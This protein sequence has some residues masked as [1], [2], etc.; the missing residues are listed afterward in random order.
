VSPAG[1]GAW[2]P[3]I[4]EPAFPIVVAGHV[5]HGKST[6]IGRLLHDTDSLPDGKAEEVR[7]ISA[8]RGLETEWSFVLDALQLERDQ[9]ITL[10]AS[11]IWFKT[12]RRR[13]VII[14][15]PGHREFLRNML[16]GASAAQAAVL[17]VD[18]VEGISEQT[19]RHAYLLRLLGIE[20]VIVV[21]NKMDRV[22]HAQKHFATVAGAIGTYLTSIGLAG[23]TIIPASARFGDGIAKRSERLAWHRGPTLVEALDVL[24][25][26]AAPD[27]LP[28]R[29]PVQDVY[30]DGD[31]RILVGRIEAGRLRPGERVRI[32]PGGREVQVAGFADGRAEGNARAS[33]ALRLVEAAFVERGSLLVGADSPPRPGEHI[34][35]RVALFAS[36]P[37]RQG[38]ALRL[39]IGPSDYPVALASIDRLVDVERL[40]G[41]RAAEI[42]PDGIAEVTLVAPFPLPLDTAAESLRTGRGVLLDQGRIIGAAIIDR[43]ESSAARNN[44]GGGSRVGPARAFSHRGAVLWLTGLSG[45]GKST[46]A[47]L[48]AQRLAEAGRNATVLDGDLMRQGLSRD[49]GFSPAD[50]AENVRR[51]AEVARLFA[52]AGFVAIVAMISPRREDRTLARRIVGDGFAEVYVRAPLELCIARDPKGLYAK[53]IAGSIREFTGIS[54]PYEEPDAPN[55]MLDTQAMAESDGVTA[56]RDLAEAMLCAG[57]GACATERD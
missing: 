16:S 30:R 49:L 32:L 36:A 9:G 34:T 20:Q 43:V 11:R 26:R 37:V 54:A 29:L 33:V 24:V 46:L 47:R 44:V 52:D 8:L 39:R 56:L 6:L 55:L 2:L 22:G 18:A 40:D 38:T 10:D 45:S 12:A 13:Y 21:I 15:A 1:D 42:P 25:R 57:S 53:A 3:P 51:V 5:D 14:D 27:D 41:T 4:T 50:R 31:A 19:R 28:L 35:A 17:V 23:P 48:L 7:R